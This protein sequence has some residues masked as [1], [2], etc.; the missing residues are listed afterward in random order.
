MT[1]EGMRLRDLLRELPTGSV[2]SGDPEVRVRG[3]HQDSREVT[4]GDLFVA[5]KGAHADGGAFVDAA[6]SRGAA[7]LLTDLT[8]PCPPGVPCIRV[9]DTRVGLALAAAAV[10]GHPAF[11]LEIVGVT[12]T[13]GKTTTTHL[14]KTAI[15]GAL[16]RPS[17][18]VV[19]TV[20]HAFG[21][22]RVSASHTTPEAD[23]LARVFAAM[24]DLGAT[25]VAMEVSS[26]ALAA[27]RVHA[28][29]FRVAA[30]TNLTQ[31][32]LDY[33]GSMEEYAA[34]KA[35]LFTTCAPA[36]AVI[37]VG[38]PFGR[39]L[40]AR[41]KAPLVRV[42]AALGTTAH[43]AD[44]APLGL[45]LSARGI[46]ARVRTPGGE[47]DLVSPMFGAHN[48]ENLLVTLG[49]VV[50]L[51]LDVE[52][53]AMAL[54]GEH[55]APGRLERCESPE[56]DV[57]VLVDYAH[58]PDALV[59]A[60]ASV[61]ALAKGRVVVVFGCGG[62]RDRAKRGPMGEAAAQGADLVVVTNDNPRT[63]DPSEIVRPIV[64]SLERHGLAATVPDLLGARAKAYVVELDR[65]RAIEAA[66]LAAAPG[67]TVI[68]CGKGHEE[69]Q[70]VGDRRAPFD[71]RVEARRSLALRRTRVRPA[72]GALVEG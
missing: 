39:E 63:E 16:G 65:A 55:G 21:S 4:A 71:D 62:D 48:V 50:A 42:S 72:P 54:R 1:G 56:D 44:V 45:T 41:V 68:V 52:R 29:R 13:N 20:G 30:F 27:R 7:A 24:R 6:M 26:I 25:H 11:S 70:I 53:A 35:E 33:H 46:E 58:T 5:R 57:V 22:Y 66:V 31:D 43:D 60:L 12:G 59:R 36:A 38:D 18:G 10:Y 2:L 19:G 67:D 61:R 40:A 47:V 32:H 8:G 14:I 28:V 51:G 23:D 17:C 3:V 49:V 9:A 69:Y 15:D 37:H 64:A 34:A